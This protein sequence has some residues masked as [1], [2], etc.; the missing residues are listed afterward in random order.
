M[1]GIGRAV[2]VLLLASATVAIAQNSPPRPPAFLVVS[3]S[4]EALAPVTGVTKLPASYL[5]QIGMGLGLNPRDY[6]A[7]I[8]SLAVPAD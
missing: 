3:P 4:P 1:T 8:V 7:T 5:D 2:A 6:P